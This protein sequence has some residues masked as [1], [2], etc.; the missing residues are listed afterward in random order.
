MVAQSTRGV[1]APMSVKTLSFTVIGFLYVGVSVKTAWKSAAF[2]R[3][4]KLEPLS[5]ALPRAFAFSRFL[6]PL[7]D[8]VVLTIDLL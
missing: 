8:S 7:G 6:Y 1:P 2:R 3:E 5:P 4:A